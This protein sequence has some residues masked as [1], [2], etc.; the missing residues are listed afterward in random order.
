MENI[1]VDCKSCV[2]LKQ[3]ER[4][5][6]HLAGQDGYLFN[7]RED[8]TGAVFQVGICIPKSTVKDEFRAG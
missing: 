5:N 6:H 8:D 7:G 1:A 2:V 4:Q 3:I